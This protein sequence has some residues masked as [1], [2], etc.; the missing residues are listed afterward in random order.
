[1]ATTRYLS[2][3]DKLEARLAEIAA[4]LGSGAEV[5]VGFMSGATYQEDG[6]SVALVAALNEFGTS[7]AP[8]RPF[9]RNAIAANSDKWPVNVATALKANGYDPAKALDLVGQEIQ[10]EIQD[11]IR[12]NTPP[13][14]APSTV[15][16]KG[17]DKTLIDTGFMLDSVTHR[18]TKL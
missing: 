2:G 9:F 7:K 15:A 8:P 3:G 5:E 13:P 18:V 10:E 14:N 4:K 6:T 16:R 12:S 17:F 1:M 11:S